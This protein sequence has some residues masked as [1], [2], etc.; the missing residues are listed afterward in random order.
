MGELVS[1]DD[2]PRIKTWTRERR[3]EYHRK[4]RK[5]NREKVRLYKR[6]HVI[7]EMQKKRAATAA[8]RAEKADSIEH[9]VTDELRTLPRSAAAAFDVGSMYYFN[10]LPCKHGHVSKRYARTKICF[11]CSREYKREA[12]R[13]D[14]EKMRRIAR[15]YGARN[16]APR[17]INAKNQK[18]KR[19][20]AEGTFS[21]GD[22]DRIFDAQKR[23]CAVCKVSIGKIYHVDHIVPIAKGGTNWPRNIQLLCPS[24]NMAKSAK[25]PVEFMRSKG[26]LL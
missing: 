6:P 8:K 10:G 26:M 14:P 23:K 19:R 16:P 4:W 24:C 20:S 7:K 25:D 5:E 9:L 13:A 1:T 18:A 22:V 12:Y 11:E 2:I 17:R 21:R 15:E 3:N